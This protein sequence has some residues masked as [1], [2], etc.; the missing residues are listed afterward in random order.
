[1]LLRKTFEIFRSLVLNISKPLFFGAMTQDHAK[2]SS[3]LQRLFGYRSLSSET[4]SSRA[5]QCQQTILEK[6]LPSGYRQRG[7]VP[8]C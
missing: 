2:N 3:T 8:Y 1:L 4:G 6:E 7:I 5:L